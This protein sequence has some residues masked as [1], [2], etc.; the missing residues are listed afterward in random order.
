MRST[1]LQHVD[2]RDVLQALRAAGP[3][4]VF[5]PQDVWAGVPGDPADKPHVATD[6]RRLIGRENRQWHG[7]DCITRWGNNYYKRRTIYKRVK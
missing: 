3:G 2:I 6:D 1:H 4:D 7:K 5:E